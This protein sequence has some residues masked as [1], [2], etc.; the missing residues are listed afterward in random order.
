MKTM[1]SAFGLTYARVDQSNWE[2][3]ADLQAA[4]WPDYPD[5]KRFKNVADS[6]RDDFCAFLAYK[7]GELVGLTGV[8][9]YETEEGKDTSIWMGW[10]VVAPEMRGKGFGK[11]ILLDTIAYAKSLDRFDYFRIDTD[12]DPDRPAIHLYEK[13]MELGEPYTAEDTETEKQGYY[14]YSTGLKKP[15]V[16]WNNRFLGLNDYYDNCR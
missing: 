1:T 16:P 8:S 6:P 14:I 10:F 11:A 2:T 12:Y 4:E 3:A 7:D 5:R 15:V 9:G 13:Y